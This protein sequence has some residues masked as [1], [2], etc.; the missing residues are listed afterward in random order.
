[1]VCSACNGSNPADAAFCE[2]CG[3]ALATTPA[4][5]AG[6]S[7]VPGREFLPGEAPSARTGQTTTVEATIEAT[8]ETTV[9]ATI[10]SCVSCGNTVEDDYCT[11]CGVKQPS[12]RD[13]FEIVRSTRLAGVCD[14]GIQH[15]ANQDAMAV[16]AGPSA[17]TGVLVVCDGVTSAPLS[18]RAALAAAGAACASLQTGFRVDPAARTDAFW[19]DA[20]RTACTAAQVETIAVART[21]GDPPEPPS[22]TFVAAVIDADAIHVGWCGD[23][24]AYWLP[25]SGD[26]KILSIDDSIASQL[27]ATGTS[28]IDA[29]T[30]PRAHTITR[31]LGA[32]AP[33][34]TARVA[35]VKVDGSGWVAVVSDGMWNYASEPAA[36]KALL[37]NAEALGTARS[38][39]QYANAQGGVDNITVA[40]LRLGAPAQ[41]TQ[42]NS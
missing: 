42:P 15:A 21:L 5:T 37:G 38:M 22:C 26:G 36:L 27:I 3:V 19:A 24:R 4:G 13:H 25:D 1:M 6:A 41:P 9:E 7:A 20:L 12:P 33:D 28:R 34:P 2:A 11:V 35:S 40:L 30:D 10:I 17:E 14:R 18:E 31:W 39:V 29:E 23:S 16:A 32:D 8:V